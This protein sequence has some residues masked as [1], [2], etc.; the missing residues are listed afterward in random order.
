M[1]E[2][3]QTLNPAQRSAVESVDGAV[4]VLAGAG[5]GKTRVLTNR[6][7][8]MICEK[9]VNPDNILAIT[10]TN[11][12]AFEMKGRL[13]QMLDNIGRMLVSTIH[14]MCTR[15]L[16]Y[17]ANSLPG[18]TSNF[19][20]YT[21]SET[22]HI[23]KTL[24][25]KM[26]LT[27]RESEINF[28]YHIGTAKNEA[29][30][31]SEYCQD[32]LEGDE[33]KDIIYKV[34][35]EY[36]RILKANNAMDFDDLLYNAYLLFKD[37]CE[38]LTKYQNRFQYINIDEFQDTNRVQYLMFKLL[39]GSDG[40]IFVVG[41]DD[42]SIYGWR[43]A[44]VRNLLDFKKDFPNVKIIKLE[45]NYRSTKKILSVANEII[46][47]NTERYPKQLWTDN[48]EGAKVEM[49]PAQ[50]ESDEAFYIISQIAAL[51]RYNGY[52]YK[53]CAILMRI[54]A[55]SR[56]YEQEL[57]K[58][59]ISYKIFG[60]FKFFERKEVKDILA[61]LRLID[62]EKDDEAFYRIIN[63]PKRGIGD[64]SVNRLRVFSEEVH[65]SISN[66]AL[67]ADELTSITTAT[68]IKIQQFGQMIADMRNRAQT[69]DLMDFL[70]QLF[71]KL[72]LRNAFKLE[73]ADYDKSIIVD[74]FLQAAEE[75]YKLNT[76]AKLSDFLQSVSLQSDL[77]KMDESDYV[78]I[79]TVH[80]AKGLEFKA[81]F[82][83]GLEQ[84]LFPVSRA[85][86]NI[87]EMEEER[88]LMYVAAT[89]AKERLFL[90][91]A[92]SRFLYGQHKEQAP[93]LFYKELENVLYPQI[94]ET[95][96][97]KP[98]SGVSPDWVGDTSN[99]SF[100]GRTKSD[101]YKEK[102]SYVNSG[103]KN[104]AKTEKAFVNIYTPG[105]KI[106]HKMFGVGTVIAAK[107][108][109]IDVAFNKIGVKTLAIKFAPIQKFEE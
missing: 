63:S 98:Q 107:D 82:V 53:D 50:N 100:R 91:R 71:D 48:D 84:G 109:N 5:S 20:I 62:N 2:F 3:L 65:L 44:D 92:A 26:Q 37:N 80:S 102:Y 68:R 9:G 29:M 57:I 81:V 96:A 19:S 73:K 14:S 69:S 17:E 90:T 60:G 77:D 74:E 78:T 88:R 27:E 105:M 106:V 54:N 93:S 79:A 83:A 64:T 39:S 11:K 89:R 25:K 49:Y 75:F 22:E 38:I 72:D 6:I 58:Y 104:A 42:Q 94:S 70:S 4:M 15:I 33:F 66:A 45:Q 103:F 87:K 47:K 34:M 23:L 101:Y 1:R 85:N 13:M 31:I 99:D 16:R 55:L 7:A 76:T 18:Y 36:E 41:D 46:K 61:Y 67:K 108:E 32:C 35:I 95:S 24:V 52:D 59:G 86:F 8:Y 51:K 28:L 56:S 12:A 43:G 30:S 97:K 21:E 10:F 40:N